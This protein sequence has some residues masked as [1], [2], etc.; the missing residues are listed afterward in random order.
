MSITNHS[1][2][3]AHRPALWAPTTLLRL[4]PEIKSMILGNLDPDDLARVERVCKDLNAYAKDPS[5]WCDI[6]AR[7]SGGEPLPVSR[8]DARAFVQVVYRPPG[9]N[10]CG[11]TYNS[12]MYFLVGRRL[13]RNHWNGE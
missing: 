3:P 7:M 6:L 11:E 5:P 12:Y 8:K 9:C 1:L 13:C 4:P 10:V 2:L